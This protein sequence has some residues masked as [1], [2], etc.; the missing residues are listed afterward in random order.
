MR[1]FSTN[2]VVPTEGKKNGFLAQFSE[3][4]FGSLQSHDGLSFDGVRNSHI[5]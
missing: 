2:T 3:F 1:V 4:P 5:L